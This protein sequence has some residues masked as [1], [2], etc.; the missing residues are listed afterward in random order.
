MPEQ[1]GNW[2]RIKQH[3][4]SMQ[5]QLTTSQTANNIA[6]CSCCKCMDN[7][8][9]EI[10]LDTLE[11][12]N[13]GAIRVVTLNRPD[14]LNA[15]NGQMA[16]ELT[17]TFKTAASDDSVKVIVLTGKGKAFWAGADLKEPPEIRSQWFGEMVEAA[18]DLPQPLLIAVNGVGV[19]IGATI[20][21]LA[22]AV[23]LAASARLRCPFSALGL[24]AEAASTV[25]FPQLL[26][27][28]R[29]SWL[30]LASEWMTAEECVAV[31]LALEVVPDD[32]LIEYVMAQAGKL[33]ALPLAS[34][35]QTKS[36]I[37]DPIREQ[38][39]LAVK[40]ENAA[41]ADMRGK[42]ANVE[43]LSAFRAKRAPD[44]TGL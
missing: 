13:E 11:I 41:L 2:L 30:L 3:L 20:C 44:F 35:K 32:D 4:R 8:V 16:E 5:C 33:A 21:G 10:D 38:L 18:I 1:R 25:T 36:L 37:V 31:G 27:R 14:A 22:D 19:G 6:S 15:L 26:G 23:Y 7:P 12:S 9:R 43:A 17:A 39:K 40:A 34:L 24:T 28:Q 42:A 29:A